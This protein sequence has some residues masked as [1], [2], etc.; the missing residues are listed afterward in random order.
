MFTYFL[1]FTFAVILTCLGHSKE[2]SHSGLF[3]LLRNT[4]ILCACLTLL[5]HFNNTCP[6]E[7][8]MSLALWV[9]GFVKGTLSYGQ[10]IRIVIQHIVFVRLCKIYHGAKGRA[11]HQF[12]SIDQNQQNYDSGKL[13]IFHLQSMWPFVNHYTATLYTVSKG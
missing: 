8:T 5:I 4:C 2:E 7:Y 6:G 10:V 11:W 13:A 12:V 1:L 9:I 3:W